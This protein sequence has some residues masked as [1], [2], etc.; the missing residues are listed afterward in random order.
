MLWKH[1]RIKQ[2]QEGG[3]RELQSDAFTTKKKRGAY[4]RHTCP[5]NMGRPYSPI[6]WYPTLLWQIWGKYGGNTAGILHKYGGIWGKYGGIWGCFPIV[7][8]VY[9][10]VLSVLQCTTVYYS[11]LQCTT[12]Y[13]SVLQCTTVY[14]SVLQCTTVYYSVLQCTTVYYSVLQ[15]TTVYY[16]VLQCTTVYYSVLQCTTVY[17]SVL[18]CTTVY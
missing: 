13:Y 3:V 5:P 18:Q 7:F 12:V 1:Q 9:Y 17:Y 10:S 16:S 15:C 2:L 8:L 4:S 11:V 6:F 14:Y